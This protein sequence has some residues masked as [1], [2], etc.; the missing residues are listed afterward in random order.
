MCTGGH[1]RDR[2]RRR[3]RYASK[4]STS[5]YTTLAAVPNTITGPATVNILTAV[6]V[7]MPSARKS[8]AGEAT[9]LAK[10]VMG[11]SVPAPAYRASR[12]YSPSA[13]SS[14]D[15]NT[16]VTEVAEAA[17]CC[18]SP[19]AC[20]PL[21]ISCPTAQIPPPTT[22]ASAVSLP[23]GELGDSCRTSASYS[24]GVTPSHPFPGNMCRFHRCYTCQNP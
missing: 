11:T 24:L 15:R 5:P 17:S 10:P 8:M 16:S 21:A 1:G 2:Q 19:S 18:V 14:T 3:S 23:M 6:P 13:V 4:Y 12:W 22:K 20:Q 9:A 7:T